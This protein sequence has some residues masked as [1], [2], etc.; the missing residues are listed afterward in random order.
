MKPKA[1]GLI[2][3]ACDQEFLGLLVPSSDLWVELKS[4]CYHNTTY[5]L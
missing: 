5:K 2:T 3:V 1:S 4:S